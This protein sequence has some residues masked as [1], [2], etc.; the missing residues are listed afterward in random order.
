MKYKA[1]DIVML[2]HHTGR[3]RVYTRPGGF[4]FV[5]LDADVWRSD[6]TAEVEEVIESA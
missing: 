1:W 2:Q 3:Y 6:N 5:C 4:L